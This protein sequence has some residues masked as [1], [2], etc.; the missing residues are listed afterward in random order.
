MQSMRAKL[1]FMNGM[2]KNPAS[3]TQDFF[4]GITQMAPKKGGFLDLTTMVSAGIGS[5]AAKK[6]PNFTTLAWT[7][8]KYVVV[9]VAVVFALQALLGLV[10]IG[11]ET[12]VPVAPSK[13]GDKKQVTPSGNVL[14]Y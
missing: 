6:S 1:P 10:R 4:V 14:L 3:Q 5:Y 12:F 8:L 7:L 11:T 2:D 9:A 13:E